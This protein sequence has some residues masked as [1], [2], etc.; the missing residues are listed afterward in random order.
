[1]KRLALAA[2][3]VAATLAGSYDAHA[4]SIIRNPNPPSYHVEIEP[5]VIFSNFDY[6]GNAGFGGGARFS[7]PLMSPGFV[8]S[9]NDSVAI[10][11]GADLVHYSGRYWCV[12]TGCEDANFWALYV[13][14]A[15]QWN[16]WFTEQ[17]SAFAELGAVFRNG[18]SDCAP[19]YACGNTFLVDPTFSVGGRWMF[20]EGLSLTMRAG[21]PQ[22]FSLGLS[23]F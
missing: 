16:F 3:A 21:W 19:G 6:A 1:M 20:T 14:V 7:I 15:A 17:W 2:V 9:I 13:P 5:H 4:A 18:F 8:R 22:G 10:S 23:I 12:A 11:F